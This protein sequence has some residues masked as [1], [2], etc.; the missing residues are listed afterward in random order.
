[1]KDNTDTKALEEIKDFNIGDLF[2]LCLHKWYWITLCLVF[3]VG[4]SLLYIYRKQPEYKRYEQILINDQ[5]SGGGGIGDVPSAFSSLGLFSKNTNVYNELL[6]MTSPAVLYQVVD[7]LQLYMNYSLR[8]G[9]RYKTLYGSNQPFIIEMKDIDRQESASFKMKLKPNGDMLFYRFVRLL[10]DSKI[11]YKDEIEVKGGTEEFQ[12]PLGRISISPNPRYVPESFDEER[13]MNVGKMAVQTTVE[14]YGLKLTGDLA[15]MDSD[16]IELSIEDVSVERAVD[17]LNYVLLVYNQDWLEDKNRITN[18]TSRFIDERLR[19][20]QSELGNVDET[21]A[22]Y[23][24]QSGTP[25]LTATLTAQ[26]GLTSTMEQNYIATNNDLIMATYMKE[27]LNSHKDITTVLPANLG[28]DNRELNV[29]IT[30][31]NDMLLE[32]NNILSNSSEDNPLVQNLDRQL[33]QMR[34]AIENSID[35]Q[36]EALKNALENIRK[37]I[38]RMNTNMANT[39]GDNLP[40]LSEERQQKVKEALYLFLLQR[41]EE[42]ELTQKYTSDNFRLITPPVGP[43]KPVSPRK[44]LIIIV[45]VILGI[46]IPVIVLYYL[47]ITD[48]TIRNKQDFGLLK[49]TF[50]GEIPQVGKKHNIKVL[51][52]KLQMRKKRDEQPPLAVVEEGK[53][54]TV[55]EAFRVIRGNMDFITGKNVG[56]QVIMITSFTPR[57]GKSFIAYNLAISYALKGK[58]VLIID[59]DLR[60]DSVSRLVVSPSKGLSTYLSG[61][62]KEWETLVRPMSNSNLSILPAGTIPLNPSEL[63]D[64]P[65]MTELVEEAKKNYDMVFLDCPPVNIVVDTQI[66]AQMADRTIFIIRAGMEE[67]SELK[68]LNLFYEEDKYPNM[69]VILNGTDAQQGGYNAY[70]HYLH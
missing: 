36:I 56:S 42:N 20:I 64:E 54:D 50:V 68:E 2:K 37:E 22:D 19:I 38:D 52:E 66:L 63:L 55:N 53:R 44:G 23:L 57:S 40:L 48:N 5:D 4:I 34:A 13:V 10:P 8:D 33:T 11:K 47:E 69:S 35:N 59:C 24:R 3:S 26:L 16:V 49:P 17:I 51:T 58:K 29:Q 70:S 14:L 28:M 31:F 18:A 15:D 25:D 9:L 7:S 62:D 30:T 1:M 12:S 43:L 67:K 32:R 65:K 39:P 21:I 41:R 60:H 61:D 27:F 45:A 46:G 6:T